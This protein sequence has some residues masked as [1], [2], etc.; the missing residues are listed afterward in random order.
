MQ[1]FE[2]TFNRTIIILIPFESC[3]E[4]YMFVDLKVHI[5]AGES[6]RVRL[7][8]YRI[9]KSAHPAVAKVTTLPSHNCCCQCDQIYWFSL[10][11]DVAVGDICG[12]R[13]PGSLSVFTQN[14]LAFYCYFLSHAILYFQLANI[15]F[16]HSWFNS[17]GIKNILVHHY[18]TV[19]FSQNRSDRGTPEEARL[20]ISI[21][22]LYLLNDKGTYIYCCISAG[23]Y[24]CLKIVD[25]LFFFC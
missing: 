4:F 9:R 24:L 11:I 18:C 19:F 23:S 1:Y 25:I 21:S 15:I 8:K 10:V 22:N 2:W 20:H 5:S 12:A 16:V 3:L 14:Q 6:R 17:N 7:W 13:R